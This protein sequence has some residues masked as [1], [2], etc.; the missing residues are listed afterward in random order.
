MGFLQSFV[1]MRYFC[2]WGR[3]WKG[4]CYISGLFP[5]VFLWFSWLFEPS[6]IT[7]ESPLLSPTV[8]LLC[9]WIRWG[10]HC[11]GIRQSAYNSPPQLWI[12]QH[13]CKTIKSM[14]YSYLFTLII[15]RS[16]LRIIWSKCITW[17]QLETQIAPVICVSFYW[18]CLSPEAVQECSEAAI[19]WISNQTLVYSPLSVFFS[20]PHILRSS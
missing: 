7:L 12:N 13:W 15:Q 17:R 14:R 1:W 19:R 2:W 10:V 11:R 18:L 8:K 20:V 5:C 9:E 16:T 4:P 3:W 6:F